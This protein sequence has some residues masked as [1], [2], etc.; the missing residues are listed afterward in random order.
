MVEAAEKAVESDLADN[1]AQVLGHSRAAASRAST[2]TN[3]RSITVSRPSSR[4]YYTLIGRKCDGG[5]SARRSGYGYK[6]T[7][8]RP[9]STSAVPPKADIL[10]AVTD[11]RL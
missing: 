1:L 2:T 11:F 6:Q 9:K 8:S 4:A 3:A 10:V 7:S 5:W